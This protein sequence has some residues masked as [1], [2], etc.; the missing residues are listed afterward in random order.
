MIQTKDVIPS[1][2]NFLDALINTRHLDEQELYRFVAR[3]C[4]A[5]ANRL[6]GLDPDRNR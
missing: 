5:R 6:A 4:N 3:M 1:V 2:E